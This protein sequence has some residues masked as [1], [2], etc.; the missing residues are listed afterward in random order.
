M[1]SA[2]LLK[3]LHF[4]NTTKPIKKPRTYLGRDYLKI[5]LIF[6]I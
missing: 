1:S 5:R 6:R 3:N 2:K 4:M